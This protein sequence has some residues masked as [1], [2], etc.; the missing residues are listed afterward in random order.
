MPAT[1]LITENPQ[2]RAAWLPFRSNHSNLALRGTTL[3]QGEVT[4]PQHSREPTAGTRLELRCNSCE[5]EVGATDVGYAAGLEKPERQTSTKGTHMLMHMGKG[6]LK[7]K[8]VVKPPRPRPR[9]RRLQRREK[10]RGRCVNFLSEADSS[11]SFEGNMKQFLLQSPHTEGGDE[12]S[13]SQRHS[14]SI[15]DEDRHDHENGF[16]TVAIALPFFSKPGLEPML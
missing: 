5:W 10:Q 11:G 4:D 14:A 12:G 13:T 7:S 1:S 2:P 3:V 9:P 8:G 16:G 15:V 6:A